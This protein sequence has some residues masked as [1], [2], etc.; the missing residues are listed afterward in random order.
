MPELAE[1]EQ[2]AGGAD[3]LV[4]HLEGFDGPLD[5]LLDLARRQK[6]DLARI[7]ILSL[8][9]QYLRVIEG[10][11]RVRLELA[12]EWLVMAAWLTWLKSR[13][14]LPA[15]TEAA[16]EAEQAAELLA[17]RLR[18]LQAMR[19]AAGWLA[20]R[21]QLRHEV[22]AR[23]EPENFT[24]ADR[25]R[26]LMDNAGLVRAYL[27]AVRRGNGSR[28]YSPPSLTLW[29]VADA[30]ARLAGLVRLMPDWTALEAFLPDRLRGAAAGVLERRAAT[31]STL[32]AGLEMARGGVLRLRQDA[33]FAPILVRVNQTKADAVPQNESAPQHD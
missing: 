20:E 7:S 26:I 3:S 22:F 30:L 23:G 24:E 25:S 2:Q 13:L 18:D 1:I 32:V 15:G 6:L 14:L 19:A 4:V 10:V 11:G 33:A 27:A 5:L 17:T 21:P 8:V 9:D 12:A 28:S 31:A 16:E 29:S